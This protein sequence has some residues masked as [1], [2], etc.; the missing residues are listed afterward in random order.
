MQSASDKQEITLMKTHGHRRVAAEAGIP[1]LREALKTF[2]IP[3]D[4]YP[5]ELEA[6][7]LGNWLTDCSQFKDPGGF[8]S[9]KPKM[10][11][12]FLKDIGNECSS[13]LK[14]A[15][16]AYIK[17]LSHIDDKVKDRYQ[18]EISNLIDSA[19]SSYKASIDDSLATKI[20]ENIDEF[21]KSLVRF[22]A[23]SKFVHPLPGKVKKRIDFDIFLKIFKRR[24]VQ[25][26]PHEH[27]DRPPCQFTLA[28]YCDQRSPRASYA[29]KQNEELAIYSYLEG[30]LRVA[31]GTLFEIDKK[32]AGQFLKAED[33]PPN[34]NAL[35]WHLELADLG[36]AL[37]AIEDFFAHSNF[38]EVV[39]TLLGPNFITDR[40]YDKDLLRKAAKGK[41]LSQT[42]LLK[43]RKSYDSVQKIY[44]RLIR[45]TPD[46]DRNFNKTFS[47][48]S[49]RVQQEDKYIF[50]GY[51]DG[52]DTLV[53]ILQF[54]LE[55]FKKDE[56][57][58]DNIM[59][60]FLSEV[61]EDI[62]GHFISIYK[63]ISNES[64]LGRLDQANEVFRAY[65]IELKKTRLQN[66]KEKTEEDHIE[67]KIADDIILIASIIFDLIIEGS[68]VLLITF[69]IIMVLLEIVF[70]VEAIKT[71]M[72]KKVIVDKVKEVLTKDLPLFLL[73]RGLRYLG[74]ELLADEYYDLHA[75]LFD[76]L[77]GN[78]IG[79]HSLMAKDSPGEPLYDE[80]FL[81]AKTVHWYIVDALCRW[82]NQEWYSRAKLD[83]GAK[84]I[85]WDDLVFYF[86]R[87]PH[88]TPAVNI[89]Q[90]Y[91]LEFASSYLY[92]TTS[93]KETLREIYRKKVKVMDFSYE[94]F[95]HSNNI[96]IPYLRS[97]IAGYTVDEGKLKEQL[98]LKKIAIPIVDPTVPKEH[99]YFIR[100][101]YDIWIPFKVVD[102][103]TKLENKTWYSVIVQLENKQWVNFIQEYQQTRD[104]MSQPENELYVWKY[105]SEE[106]IDRKI[107]N[108]NRLKLKLEDAYN[109]SRD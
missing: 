27:L 43:V 12:D 104:I 89:A 95:L 55:Q 34:I 80:M 39:M 21:I 103:F 54:I 2:G 58:N 1:R 78:R 33:Q 56:D 91:R 11:A 42:E 57:Q 32:W 107:E 93:E 65:L 94:E 74:K 64:K 62:F 35:E 25:Y 59:L 10:L 51:F 4:A 105:T 50:T 17:N 41:S 102:D 85:D 101:G 109:Q 66:L 84:W 16:F 26:F 15:I 69:N 40:V 81:C 61:F 3:D 22:S 13:K 49:R 18:K 88:K 48:Y 83:D 100:S 5:S 36:Y 71:K 99:S 70:I 46:A 52:R 76:S 23:Y 9:T 28:E 20:I 14:D 108:Y 67:K 29:N 31:V 63:E 45:Y 47:G 8:I 86:L 60:D 30:N 97:P 87:N 72:I 7:Y 106:E 90:A 6:F 38:I 75:L 68:Q 24:Y 77:G 19:H 96:E 98:I 79:S 73:K 92:Q 53:A 44:K 37:H 82:S